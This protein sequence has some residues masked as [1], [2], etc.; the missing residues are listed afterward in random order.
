MSVREDPNFWPPACKP[1]A[2]LRRAL[3][4]RLATDLKVMT[5]PGAFRTPEEECCVVHFTVPRPDAVFREETWMAFFCWDEGQRPC[6]HHHHL[7]EVFLA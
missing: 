6:S 5:T 1:V 3:L 4:Q 7:H 2:D